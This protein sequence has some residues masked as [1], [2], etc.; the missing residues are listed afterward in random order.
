ML[1]LIPKLVTLKFSSIISKIACDQPAIRSSR[2][3][4]PLSQQFL[5][6]MSQYCKIVR[7]T[8]H[9]ICKF[10]RPSPSWDLHINPDRVSDAQKVRKKRWVGGGGAGYGAVKVTSPDRVGS[11]VLNASMFFSHT[12]C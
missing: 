3:V 8:L 7:R 6:K 12:N 5:K 10:P 11:T 4:V 2:L 1:H 9:H